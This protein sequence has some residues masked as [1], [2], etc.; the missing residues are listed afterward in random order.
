[1]R[2]EWTER[3]ERP[4]WDVR[5][6]PIGGRIREDPL[7][8]ASEELYQSCVASLSQAFVAASPP[9]S[10]LDSDIAYWAAVVKKIVQRGERPVLM[11]KDM[12]RLHIDI[13]PPE[14]LLATVV[15]PVIPFD[16]DES[17]EPHQ[18]FEKPLWD[19]IQSETPLARWCTPQS[20]LE[21]IAGEFDTETNRWVDWLV[22]FPWSTRA[23]V[24]EVDGSGH[25]RQPG[26]DRD[27]DRLLRTSGVAVERIPGH[28]V[29][30]S[31]SQVMS[32]LAGAAPTWLGKTDPNLTR[33][34]HVPAA[35]QRL[36]FA[37]V[38]AVER[39]FL[40]PGEP[41]SIG[42]WSDIEG[43]EEL[44]NVA[45]DLLLAVADT[46]QLEIVPE[47]VAVNDTT[48]AIN[49]E[50]RFAPSHNETATTRNV[51]IR[52]EAFTPPH[53]SLGEIDIPTVVVRGAL[54]P[55]QLSWAEPPSIERRNRPGT[56]ESA[57]ALDRLLQDVLGHNSY[58]EAQR[59]AI[60][61]VLTGGD[62]CVLLPTGSGKSLIYQMAGLLRPGVTIVVAPLKS[63]I[64]DQARRLEDLGIDRVI[65][66]HS[67]SA[68]DSD[69]KKVLQQSV[70]S[71]EALFVLVAPE[72][73]QIEDF[74]RALQ[75]AASNHLVNL[76]VVDEAHCVSEWG[77]QFRTSYLR[78]GRNLRRLCMDETDVPPPILAL[79]ATASPRVLNDMLDE[80]GLDRQEPGVLHRPASFD[81]PNL[82]YRV[83]RGEPETREM[84]VLEAL[85]YIATSQGVDVADLGKTNGP[86]T[87][88][89]IV[90]VPHASSGMKLGLTHFR[91][92]IS[93][94]LGIPK[95][96]IALFSGKKPKE[97]TK[98]SSWE[99]EKARS[100]DDFRT[101]RKPIMI[102]TNAFGMGI[103][104]P[105]IR[106]TVHTTMPS[107]IEAY[108]QEAGRSGRDGAEACCAL[109]VS[110]AF[111]TGASSINDRRTEDLNFAKSDI[112]IALN[113][114][115]SSF[116]DPDREYS[117]AKEVFAELLEVGKPGAEVSIPRSH[118]Q[119]MH[120]KTDERDRERALYRLL[121][122]GVIDDYTIEYGAKTFTVYIEPF[123]SETVLAEARALVRRISGGKRQFLDQLA[124]IK[125][126]NACEAVDRTLEVLI[127]ALYKTVEPARANALHEMHLLAG[128]DD[129]E[130]IR[131]KINA[132]LSEGPVSAILNKAVRQEASAMEL[133]SQLEA[134]PPAGDEEWA[135]TA[136][137]YLDAYPDQ[138]VPLVV[139]ALGEAWRRG[140]SREEFQ[141]TIARLIETLPEFVSDT[142]EQAMFLTW[143]LRQLRT[144]FEGGRWAW[145]PDIW[146]AIYDSDL[147]D[148]MVELVEEAV[149][150]TAAGGSFFGPEL[151]LVL[152]GKIQRS[153][154]RAAKITKRLTKVG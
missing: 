137:R 151:R 39:G 139:R 73:L 28:Q 86:S 136:A 10:E 71:G 118:A 12:E 124:S 70:G 27:R 51:A 141:R 49:G 101:N 106:Y 153:A 53:A 34:L 69:G 125:T 33:A 103:D 100:A 18:T 91:S 133:L 117:T 79:T 77:H 31:T 61:R 138:P 47:Q 30:D 65:G 32:R 63:L 135:G 80:L 102:S 19:W 82:H 45:L 146:H 111:G 17:I 41:W 74:R 46:W 22:C 44:T 62:T 99:T 85:G 107:S 40:P 60:D 8:N 35:V 126:T 29:L 83:F 48:W 145:S 66:M 38:E 143:V 132:Y 131:A 90:F 75:S 134:N 67:G 98:A 15:G 119:S 130:A 11:H 78:L 97:I 9:R 4:G 58:R 96:D 1:M 127:D 108:A 43:S 121:L 26:V 128:L 36:T 95:S 50:R 112:L 104:K 114:L 23:A 16:L 24:I 92:V 13:Q 72:R 105:N 52:L 122:L 57:A 140:G 84:R 37:I 154:V 142:S 64:D 6:T 113:N 42:L 129:P 115:A 152:E 20:P 89:G 7:D 87:R 148:S 81:R 55:Q 147:E 59:E 144:Y 120:R 2:V 25:V 54:L 109:V 123:T 76:A 21:A 93:K 88:S 110:N 14:K 5:Y 149:M 3:S 94:S 116:P 68:R 56:A 150:T